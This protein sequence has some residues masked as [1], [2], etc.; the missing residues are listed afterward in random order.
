MVIQL[1]FTTQKTYIFNNSTPIYYICGITTRV[2]L[3]R[4]DVL[5]YITYMPCTECMRIAN[6]TYNT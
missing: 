6:P 1:N 5:T 2:S 3:D 4:T